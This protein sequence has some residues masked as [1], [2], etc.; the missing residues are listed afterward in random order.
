ME[1]KP[2]GPPTAP[3]EDVPTASFGI[4]SI[5]AY[6]KSFLREEK[7]HPPVVVACATLNLLTMQADRRYNTPA[8]YDGVMETIRGLVPYFT[9]EYLVA[10]VGRFVRH[11]A[12]NTWKICGIQSSTSIFVSQLRQNQGNL[13]NSGSKYE[14]IEDPGGRGVEPDIRLEDHEGEPYHL[15]NRPKSC[16]TEG[17]R[18]EPPMDNSFREFDFFFAF[19]TSRAA[20][21]IDIPWRGDLPLCFSTTYSWFPLLGHTVDTNSENSRTARSVYVRLKSCQ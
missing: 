14:L 8:E 2:P 18:L 11:K 13:N 3:P 15:P 17:G 1:G 16:N 6:R 5:D 20:L 19:V 4:L 7:D 9:R 10:Y 12:R 21:P